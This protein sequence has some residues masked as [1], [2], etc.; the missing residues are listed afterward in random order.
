MRLEDI[1]LEYRGASLGDMRR[2]K[3]LERIGLEL[4]RNP[5]LSFPEAMGSEGQ[6]EALYRFLNNDDVTF[7]AV[8][9]PHAEQTR[10]RCQAEE[11]VLVL[12]DTT[13]L[14]FN[15]DRE[16]LGRL[17]EE[18]GTR[19]FRLHASLAVTPART[20]LGVLRAETW[21]RTT[22]PRRDRN[23]RHT[24]ADPQRES[25]RWGRAV[26]ACEEQL[27][28]AVGAVHVMDRE[29]D[30][31]DL[32]SELHAAKAHYV[33]RLANDRRLV[34]E[35]Q[36]LKGVVGRAVCLFQR[37]VQVSP[38]A[39]GRPRDR[40]EARQ[41]RAVTLDVSA[42]TVE[43][44]R[45]N[46]FAPSSPPSLKVNVVTV[47]EHDCPKG[48]QPIEWYLVTNEP[49]D[50]T[51]QVAAVVD[52]YRARWVIEELF[53][54]LKSGCHI[55]KRQLE[56]YDALRIALAL[57][58]PIA[59]RLLALRHAARTDPDAACAA[60]SARQLQLLRA[61]GTRPLSPTPTNQEVYMAL[62]ALGGHLRSNGPPG[63][64]VLGRAF[65]KLLV[66]EQGWLAGRRRSDR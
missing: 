61:C 2:S 20:P 10:L 30:N 47:L 52:A 19:G 46:N 35:S 48:E 55:E 64:I 9:A 11:R 66:L 32:F 44:S 43:L 5:D 57:F 49:I 60:L 50:T 51:E 24:R 3:R 4:A 34:G 18:G 25:L 54:A 38:R 16:G 23:R 42:M 14:K 58:L 56:S 65:D 6:L 7:E 27:G 15:G 45:S 22:R 29:G 13:I 33:I 8:H 63:W 17:Y 36:K 53:K 1:A 21:A 41:A 26:R 28:Q 40:H 37:E 12:H 62:A 59:V 31:Y 39:P